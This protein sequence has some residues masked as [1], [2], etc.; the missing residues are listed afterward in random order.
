MGSVELAVE[1]KSSCGSEEGRRVAPMCAR[2]VVTDPGIFQLVVK[3]GV[4][5]NQS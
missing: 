2:A 1:T 4:A 3:S 5:G